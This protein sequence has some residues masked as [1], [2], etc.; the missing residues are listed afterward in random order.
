MTMD[1]GSD[2][3]S[4]AMPDRSGPAGPFS[5]APTRPAHVLVAAYACN[6]FRG[7]EEAV[8]WDWVRSIAAIAGKVTV[9][10]FWGFW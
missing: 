4:F 8:G 5:T 7:S 1:A 6:P 10:D 9:I 2:H 3:S